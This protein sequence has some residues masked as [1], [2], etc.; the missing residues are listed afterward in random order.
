MKFFACCVVTNL[1]TAMALPALD[2]TAGQDN[3]QNDQP[4]VEKY[5]RQ[6]RV[7]TNRN[8]IQG[9]S[10]DRHDMKVRE[11][12]N[13]K[14]PA[15]QTSNI[16][17]QD[18]E[19]LKYEHLS[20]SLTVNDVGGDQFKVQKQP[21][22]SLLQVCRRM[23]FNFAKAAN[24][25]AMTG[26]EYVRG[27]WFH[28]YG[29]NIYAEGH[30]GIKNLHPMIF[31]STDVQMNGLVGD[32]RYLAL[33]S[34]NF[35]CGGFG[36]G[37]GG[38]EGKPGENCQ[39]LGNVLIPSPK[40][41]TPDSSYSIT[42][43]DYF[44]SSV[45]GILI[46]E[47]NQRTRINSIGFLNVGGHDEIMAFHNDE[48]FQKI[49]LESVGQNGFQNVPLHLDNVSRMFITLHSFAAVTGIDLCIIVD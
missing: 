31:D 39:S 20:S 28:R 3:A 49:E 2:R 12:N 16:V 35:D 10:N 23:K 47:F 46:F 14:E 37:I 42:R 27:E 7:N 17:E 9:G 6:L 8:S 22:Q 4:E 15:V 29:I 19:Q 45:G 24:G 43:D 11:R 48:S 13:V 1:F 44:Q 5:S 34:P 30:D 40:P 32:K 18:L 21:D 33:G 38:A 25:R 36:V 26:G 41:G